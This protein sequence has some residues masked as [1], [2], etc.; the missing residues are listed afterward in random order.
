M[1]LIDQVKHRN[2][3]PAFAFY[4]SKYEKL[5]V[6]EYQQNESLFMLLHGNNQMGEAFDWAS[7][8]GVAASIADTL[9]FM[10]QELKEYG[11]VHGNLKYSNILMNKNMEH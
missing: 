6:Y 3:L 10:H 2:I 9:A 4:C 11:I 5:L 8:L 1:K 7:R